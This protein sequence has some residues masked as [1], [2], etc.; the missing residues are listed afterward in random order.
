MK[1]EVLMRSSRKLKFERRKHF[2]SIKQLLITLDLKYFMIQRKL[3]YLK[4]ILQ[5][6]SSLLPSYCSCNRKQ[7][8]SFVFRLRFGSFLILAHFLFLLFAFFSFRLL[9]L[10][11]HPSFFVF[12]GA[13]THLY[14]WL[15]PSVGRSVGWLVCR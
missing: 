3:R 9:S 14:N 5:S 1:N 8:S 15:C 13:P 2:H 6:R 7:L 10:L 11:I 12:L 4:S